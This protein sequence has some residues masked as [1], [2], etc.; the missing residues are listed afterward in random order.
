MMPFLLCSIKPRI[1]FFRTNSRYCL[2]SN[3]IVKGTPKTEQTSGNAIH[4]WKCDNMVVED[5]DVQG[6]RDGIYFEFVTHSYIF[7]NKSH[8]NIR[9]GLH[10]M[11]SN[12]DSYLE[13]IFTE[14]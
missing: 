1:S 13:N 10:F 4:L 6:H 14:N 8:N 2:I 5:N 3:N 11:F 9:Y 12:N 7:G